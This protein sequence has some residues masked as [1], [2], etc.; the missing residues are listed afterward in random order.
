ML[1]T[2]V[3]NTRVLLMQLD[4]PDDLFSSPKTFVLHRYQLL[5]SLRI[6]FNAFDWRSEWIS[7]MFCWK[8]FQQNKWEDCLSTRTNMI[9]I[10]WFP[11]YKSTRD[12]M[13]LCRSKPASCFHFR[14]QTIPKLNKL[15]LN[16]PRILLAH[17][18]GYQI[19]SCQ[20]KCSSIFLVK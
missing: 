6:S 9:G 19:D 3:K 10:M 15:S 12:F 1:W 20:I 2:S 18:F 16:W 13:L 5:C 7:I 11:V 17:L 4:V 14:A 8:L